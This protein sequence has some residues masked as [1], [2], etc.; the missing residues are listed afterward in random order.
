LRLRHRLPLSFVL[1]AGLSVVVA[2]LFLTLSLQRRAVRRLAD[3]LRSQ[4]LLARDL[5]RGEADLHAAADGLADRIGQELGVRVTVIGADG[6]VLGDTDLDGEAL[7][8][9]ENHSD[10]PEVKEAQARGSGEAIRWSH[11]LGS[12]LLYVAVRLDPD[13]AGRG[14]VRLAVPLDEVRRAER[15]VVGP[16]ALAALASILLAAGLGFLA[17]G[18]LVRRLDR[19][20]GAAAAIADGQAGARTR[21]GPEDE[22]GAVERS[23][24]RMAE[25][26]DERHALL[27]R[28]RNQMQ[29]VLEGMVEGVLLT[30]A[31]GRILLANTAFERIFDA[32]PPLEGRRPLEAARVPGLQESI[33]AALAASGP[34][35]REIELLRGHQEK[36]LRASLAPL[37][38]DGGGPAG[39][40]AVFHD[41]TELKRLEQARREFV[42]NVSHELRTP[43]TA[44]KGYSETLLHGGL[45]DPGSA[46]EFVRVIDRHAERLRLLIED[47]LDLAAVEQGR[48]RLD[49][50]PTSPSWVSA[51]AVG[52]VRRAADL[53]RQTFAVD[54]P[55]DLPAIRADRDRLAQVL[56]NLLD[57]AV[58]FTPDGGRIRIRARAANGHM[59]FAVSDN[60]PGIPADE[61][62]RIFERFY[63]VERSRD[64]REGGT[65]LGLA[66]AKH[67]VQAMEGSIEAE[68]DP[69]S[70]ATFRVTLPLAG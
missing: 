15:A 70:G 12:D 22:L 32:P 44:I 41:V 20:S 58:K 24:N 52:V 66:I 45:A 54:V 4:A 26:L 38:G 9:V 55:D 51:Q 56:I 43:L 37:R 64:R 25:T 21:R 1:V 5:A 10:R 46:A 14:V 19:L 18:R 13:D 42:A 47:L 59:E 6:T 67:L 60:G 68:S 34:L 8:N 36:V 35:T 62:G 3:G 63:R 40:V 27:L 50:E 33:E 29:S 65:G 39:A 49:L 28:Q 48:A 53:K 11:T 61:L 30:D 17:S 16:V 69:G 31:T 7:R 2:A 23:L 57:N